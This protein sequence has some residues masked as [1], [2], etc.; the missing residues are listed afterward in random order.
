M[1]ELQANFKDRFENLKS[2]KTTCAFFGNPFIC[3]IIK[4]GF[5]ISEIILIAKVAVESSCFRDERGS[6]QV[7]QMLLKASAMI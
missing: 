5:P 7:L 1:K 4:N 6:L 2:L 3:D